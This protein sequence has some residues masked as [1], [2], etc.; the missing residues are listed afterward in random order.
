MCMF[1][2]VCEYLHAHK[3]FQFQDSFC[4]LKAAQYKNKQNISMDRITWETFAVLLLSSLALII[5][6]N[7]LREN[8]S[9]KSQQ[10]SKICGGKDS[11]AV[12]R[13]TIK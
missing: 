1:V 9:K 3:N 11:V 6:T 13:Y 8:K 5:V 12:T 2:R 10:I 4:S 7:S